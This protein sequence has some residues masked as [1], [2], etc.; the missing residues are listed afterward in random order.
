MSCKVKE[1]GMGILHCTWDNEEN[2]LILVVIK[3]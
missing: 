2:K 3:K 1:H